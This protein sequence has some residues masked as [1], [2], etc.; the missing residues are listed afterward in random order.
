MSH[1]IEPPGDDSPALA[2][3]NLSNNTVVDEVKSTPTST[4]APPHSVARWSPIILHAVPT[5]SHVPWTHPGEAGLA[6]RLRSVTTSPFQ[7]EEN[8]HTSAAEFT[9]TTSLDPSF[10]TESTLVAKQYVSS[11]LGRQLLNLSR[12][13]WTTSDDIVLEVFGDSSAVATD[14]L[15]AR[16]PGYSASL[17]CATVTA[18][19]GGNTTIVANPPTPFMPVAFALFVA[20]NASGCTLL[21]IYHWT[22]TRDNSELYLRVCI[23]CGMLPFILPVSLHVSASL[24]PP[25]HLQG[26]VQW[27][28]MTNGGLPPGNTIVD[29][30]Q[31]DPFVNWGVVMQPISCDCDPWFYLVTHAQHLGISDLLEPPF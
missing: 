9:L 16:T 11:Y 13:Y 23:R 21:Y 3:D 25:G 4:L 1:I 26:L 24:L 27:I 19:Y 15:I 20:F 2:G 7:L 17:D 10:L 6:P 12:P 30:R 28:N 22:G 31:V 18:L 14:R 8:V 29:S 5:G